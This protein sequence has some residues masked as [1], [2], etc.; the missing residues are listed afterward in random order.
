MIIQV[1]IGVYLQDGKIETA[2]T[3]VNYGGRPDLTL[4]SDL[5]YSYINSWRYTQS[6]LR[7]QGDNIILTRSDE[8]N[9]WNRPHRFDIHDIYSRII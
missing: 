9:D 3:Y 7:Y 8:L 4:I 1:Y 5:P 6:N 2:N